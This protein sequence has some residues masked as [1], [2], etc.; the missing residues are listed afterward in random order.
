MSI[1]IKELAK[2]LDVSPGTVSKAFNNRKDISE[3]LKTRILATAKE[4]GY[5][6]NPIARRLSLNRSQMV[7]VFILS[8]H[9]IQLQE[10]MALQFLDGIADEASRYNYDI[11]LFTVTRNTV[12]QSYMELCRQKKI[13]GAIFI[14]LTIDDPL[15]VELKE[16]DIPIVAIDCDLKGRN[17]PL[18]SS[19]NT[20]GIQLGLQYLIDMGHSNIGFLK[21]C[22][23]SE[24]S[25]IRF[26]AYKDFLMQKGLYESQYVYEGDFSRESGYR[27]GKEIALRKP[28]LTAIFAACDWMA[29]GAMQALKELGIRVPEDI[30]VVGFDNIVQGEWTEPALTTIGQDGIGMGRAAFRS[31][32]NWWEQINTEQTVLLN[33][34]L[35]VRKSVGFC[36]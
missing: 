14:G 16:T 9:D 11:L 36:C 31:I 4:L 10:S 7:G 26:K 2:R 5:T 28:P 12:K 35:I 29:I 20:Y 30:S 23:A 32:W 34:E 17:T 15:I 24:V 18:I 22:N 33:P 1:T 27:I 3:G 13:G 21:A 6:P 8:R 19:D 25:N